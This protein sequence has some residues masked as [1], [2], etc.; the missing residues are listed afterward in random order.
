MGEPGIAVGGIAGLRAQPG[1]PGLWFEPAAADARGLGPGVGHWC[2]GLAAAMDC[3]GLVSDLYPDCLGRPGRRTDPWWRNAGGD[4]QRP[5]R[6]LDRTAAG[7]RPV[8]AGPRAYAPVY[9]QCVVDGP[10]HTI[11]RASDRLA[12]RV[13]VGAGL[14]AM[15][16]RQAMQGSLAPSPASRL[17]QIDIA[18]TQSYLRRVEIDLL[19]RPSAALFPPPGGTLVPPVSP[20]PDLYQREFHVPASTFHRRPGRHRQY[21]S[22]PPGS[23]RRA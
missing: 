8:A 16:F 20:L 15:A 22:R 7:R 11:D 23:G 2:D 18:F 14:L 6:R 17:L 4:R 1:R 19:H 13:P 21:A 3:T 5:A 10:Q 9:R 12:D